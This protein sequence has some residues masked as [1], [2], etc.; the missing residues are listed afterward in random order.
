M[1]SV[2][3][4]TSMGDIQLELY[5][6]HAPRVSGSVYSVLHVVSECS[7]YDTTDMQELC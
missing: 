4:E 6:D 1:E 2:V 7:F 5:W 3:I